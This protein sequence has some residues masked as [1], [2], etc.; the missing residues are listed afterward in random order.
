[1]SPETKKK[2]LAGGLVAAVLVVPFLV[3]QAGGEDGIEVD[4]APAALQDIRPTILASGVLAYRNEVDLTAEL[5]AKVDMIAV[6]EGDMVEQ[7]QLLLKLD[8][9]TYRNAIE[10]E[11]A[12]RRQSL[13]SIQRQRVTL[14]LRQKQFERARQL[15]EAQLIGQDAFDEARNQLQVAQ[16]ELRSSEEALRRADA[17][18]GEAREQLQKTEVRSPIAGQ[19]VA[20]PIKVGETAIPSTSSLAGAQLMTIA[21]TTEI[22]AELQIDEGDIAK[23]DIGHQVEVYPAAYPDRPLRGVVE[24][25]ALAPTISGQ[26]RAYQVT[27]DIEVPEGVELRSGMSARADI[28]LSDGTQKLAVPVESVIT[29][30][31]EDDEV[32]RLGW[33]DRGGKAEKVEVETGV[34]DDGWEEITDGLDVGDRVIVGPARTLRTLQEGAEVTQAQ[35]DEDE[36]GDEA[37][38]EDEDE[39]SFS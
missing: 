33:V 30:T 18:L 8:P 34:A 7:G 25:I 6:E 11:Q 1:M 31:H 5:V 22:Q 21:N 23:V 12:T 29:D 2:W 16:V 20:L 38:A 19:V 15:A 27:V 10:R 24:Q 28:F 36:G 32:T 14:A 39:V 13:I 35:E 4:I 17:V 26:S 9:E 3:K 37:D